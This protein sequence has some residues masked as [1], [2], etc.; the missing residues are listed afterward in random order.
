M[1][2]INPSNFAEDGVDVSSV[3]GASCLF[4]NKNVGRFHLAVAAGFV[5]GFV[6]TF[7]LISVFASWYI[8]FA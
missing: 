3:F 7:G 8:F 2:Y 4:P 5:S 6:G 1:R